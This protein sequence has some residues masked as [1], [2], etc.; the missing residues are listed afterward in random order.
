MM[1]NQ[2]AIRPI[3][4][5]LLGFSICLLT[6]CYNRRISE[7]ELGP[8][9]MLEHLPAG[10]SCEALPPVTLRDGTGCGYMGGSRPAQTQTL[11]YNLKQQARRYQA[12]V[13]IL[14]GPPRTESWE[15]CASNGLIAEANL[16]RC[17]FPAETPIR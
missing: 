14:Q 16:Y 13:V 10:V 5:L 4:A 12:N 3:S 1:M 11:F 17:A 8:V 6:A 2:P 9:R 15:G 7:E